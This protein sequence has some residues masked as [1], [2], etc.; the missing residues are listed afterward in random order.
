M[1]LQSSTRLSGGSQ[2]LRWT[3]LRMLWMTHLASTALSADDNGLVDFAKLSH[4]VA[5]GCFC[6][7][8]DVRGQVL[9][10]IYQHHH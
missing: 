6:H 5:V 8:V 7:W 1:D 4:Q 2:L 9:K 3:K 10:D